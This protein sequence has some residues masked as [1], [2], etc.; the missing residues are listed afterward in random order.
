MERSA[1]GSF[2]HRR[3]LLA[4]LFLTL[5]SFVGLSPLTLGLVA[6]V[7][8]CALGLCVPCCESCRLS[9]A[10]CSC[11]AQQPSLPGSGAVHPSV[12][13]LSRG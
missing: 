7:A 4:S 3:C 11:G 10:S 2:V 1:S 9:P 8:S 12:A 5:L 6:S 13:G